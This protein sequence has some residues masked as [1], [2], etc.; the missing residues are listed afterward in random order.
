MAVM[1]ENQKSGKNWTAFNG[2]SC[3]IL[4]QIPTDSIDFSVFSPPFSNLF[5]YSNDVADMGNAESHEDFFEH[6]DFFASELARVIK[7]G[8]LI[9]VHCTDLPLRKWKDGKIGIYDFSGEIIKAHEKHG[10]IL[11]SRVT[12][13]K[14]PVIEMQRTKSIGLLH[15]Q[16]L[17]DSAKSRQGLADYLLVFRDPR[18]NPEPISH[19]RDELPVDLWQKWAS[20]VWMDIQQ[21]NTLNVKLAKEGAD[22]RHLCPLQLDLI[23]RAIIMWSN[24]GDVV[25]SPFLGIG[26]EGYMALKKKR[27]FIGIELKQSYFDIAC[28][29]LDDADVNSADLF[30]V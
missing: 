19:A 25:M 16:L 4:P 12:I 11:H 29:N 3:K 8:R 13:W 20:P 7:P 26:S 5:V 22:E 15:K 28:R 14:D 10:M 23:E 2:D 1:C 27:K 6:Y 24:P 30:S 17:K 9:A 18:E 21:G